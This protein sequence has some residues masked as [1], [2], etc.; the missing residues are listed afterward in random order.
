MGRDFNNFAIPASAPER[1]L[2]PDD[3]RRI[4]DNLRNQDEAF[5]LLALIDSE[6]Q[7]DPTSVQCFDL[8]IVQRVQICVAKRKRFKESGIL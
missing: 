1:R 2:R 6:F 5:D 4:E 7:S 8:R 3:E